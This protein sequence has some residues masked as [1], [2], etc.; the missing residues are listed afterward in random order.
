MWES[1]A[2]AGS[3]SGWVTATARPARAIAQAQGPRLAV[4]GGPELP[5]GAIAAGVA[6]RAPRRRMPRP[7]L[8]SFLGVSCV[9][10]SPLL[11][12]CS[13][14]L[15]YPVSFVTLGMSCS[16]RPAMNLPLHPFGRRLFLDGSGP[17]MTPFLS[18]VSDLSDQPKREDM[19]RLHRI[20]RHSLNCALRMQE[21]MSDYIRITHAFVSS[22][23]GSARRFLGA[24]SAPR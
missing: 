24:S 15:S 13:L 18:M 6:A 3:R 23:G 11:N 14:F 2:P 22:P 12:V 17:A 1:S 8:A 10:A 19:P 5:R 4:E 20:R 9:S 7:G 16:D 21:I